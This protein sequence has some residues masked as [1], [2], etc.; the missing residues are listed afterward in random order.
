MQHVRFSSDAVFD[1]KI[2]ALGHISVN[3]SAYKQ[4]DY[5]KN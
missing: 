3:K 1:S 2:I 5:G 4:E